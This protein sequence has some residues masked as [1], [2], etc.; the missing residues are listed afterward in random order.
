M[1]QA[2]WPPAIAYPMQALCYVA[3]AAVVGYFSAAPAYVHLAPGTA[4]VKVSLQ[5]AG[6][7]LAPCRERTP[8]E[9]AK[10]APNMRSAS[11]CARERAPV[12]VRVSLDE[13]ML[14]DLVAAPSGLGHDGASTVYH[15]AVVPA[16]SYRLK[17]TLVDDA[18]GK[19]A[20][21]VE[22]TIEVAPAQVLVLDFD[23]N[24][25]RWVVRN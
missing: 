23:G 5:H 11:V 21:T 6:Q 7:R 16:G 3:F 8:E 24:D 14:C 25:R 9:L 18:A 4:L 10:L 12:R 13:K 1:T 19:S 22:R 15:R 17:A 2:H 20:Y